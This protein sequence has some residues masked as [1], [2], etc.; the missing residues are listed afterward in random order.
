MKRFSRWTL[1]ALVLLALTTSSVFGQETRRALLVGLDL[2]D[3]GYA[4]SL[5]ACVKDA[6]AMRDVVLLGDPS[7]R[8]NAVNISL[9]S[10][11]GAHHNAIRTAMAN[12]ASESQ[13]GDLVLYY[14]SGHGG[15]H[16]GTT[17][18]FLCAYE[19]NYEDHEVA[20]D[21]DAFAEGVRVVVV[22]DTCH[23]GGLLIRGEPTAEDWPFIEGV[24]KNYNSIRAARQPD[25]ARTF[26]N[27]NV[28][29]M[30][31]CAYDEYSYEIPDRHGVY[32]RYLL[33]GAS[34][35]ASDTSADGEVQFLEMYNHAKSRA[36][37]YAP[38]TAQSYNEA[39]LGAIAARGHSAPATLA[40]AI[41]TSTNFV[42]QTGGSAPWIA[43]DF[44]AA[45]AG[46]GAAAQSDAIDH[47]QNS[48]IRTSVTGPGIVTFRWK[49]SSEED[50]DF[51][52]FLVSGTVMTSISGEQ[53]WQE[54]VF[55]IPAGANTLTWRYVQDA[56]VKEGY[57]AGWL[58]SVVWEPGKTLPDFIVQSITLNPATVPAGHPITYTV[59]VRN[60]GEEGGDAGSLELYYDRAAVAPVGLDGEF[61]YDVGW[62]DAGETRT[63]TNTFS[64]ATTGNKT[65]R[66]FIDGQNETGESNEDNNQRTQDYSVS[67]AVV[68]LPAFSPDGGSHAGAS[69]DVTVTCAT[70]GAVIHY[71]T[72]G[73][74]PTED[75]PTV[76][77]GGA[78]SVPL[79]G[80]LKA[81]AWKENMAA[82][83][84]K[85]ATY[86]S[87]WTIGDAV[88]APHLLFTT[89]GDA[90]WFIQP[91][92][93]Y[94]G[95]G[96]AQSGAITHNQQS[97]LKT[98]VT[99]PGTISFWWKVA[100]ESGY[101]KLSFHVGGAK[102]AEI[103]GLVDWQ[104][105][106]I[107]VPE[108]SHELKWT[109]AKDGSI[110]HHADA[111]WL[112]A[113]V[114]ADESTEYDLTVQS[115]NPDIGV[116]IGSSTGQAG[117]TAYL[118]TLA[119][120]AEINLEAPLYLGS[121][122]QR[123]SFV[124]WSGAFS[125]PYRSVTFHL[126][127]NTV[128][129]ANYKDDPEPVEYTLT[130]NS[131]NPAS[132]VAV[133]SSSGHGGTTQYAKS[134]AGGT[135]VAL[136]APMYVGSGL[137]RKSFVD[138]SGAL[139]STTR[140]IELT[141][142][143]HATLTASYTDDPEQHA[144]RV[145]SLNPTNGVAIASDTGHDGTT[146]YD[147]T[148]DHS[149]LVRLEAPEYHG[150]GLDRKVFQSWNLNGQS[151]AT[152]LV[153]FEMTKQTVATAIYADD[154]DA[155]MHT[156]TVASVNPATGVEIE[157]D[158][159]HF[160]IT[161]YSMQVAQGWTVRL[162]AP[163]FVGEQPDRKRFDQ[164]T[165]PLTSTQRAIEFVMPTNA[166]TATA[167]YVADDTPMTYML[168][169]QSVNPATGVSI[170]SSTA[171][172]GTTE[173]VATMS[174]G[175]TVNLVAPQYV[176]SGAERKRFN[177][178][179][180]WVTSPSL[181]I[182]NTLNGNSTVVANYVDDPEGVTYT[183]TVQSVNPA[184]GVAIASSTGH[185]GTTEYV[186][187]NIAPQTSINLQAPA[188]LGEG[189]NRKRF[190]G[191]TGAEAT[192]NTSLNF[193]M[194]ADKT[195]AANYEND[196]EEG[197][198]MW[199]DG[200]I[201]VEDRRPVFTWPA[202]P[203]ATWY[204]IYINRNGGKY[205]DQWVNVT[206]WTRTANGMAGGNYEW[207][208]QPW[209]PE[210]GYG[211]WSAKAAFTIAT[212]T[213]AA[214]VLIAPDGAQDGH[215]I[216]Y[217]WQKDINATWYRLWVGRVGGG[218]FHDKWYA[219]TGDDEATVTVTGHTLG[220]Y[221]WHLQPWGP[222]GF[223]PWAGPKGFSAP[224]ADPA[225]AEL[226]AP[227]GTIASTNPTFQ[228]NAAQNADWYRV[229][230]HKG[231]VVVFDN[232]WTQDTSLPAPFTL[233]AGNYGWWVGTWNSVTGKTEWSDG[234][235]FEIAP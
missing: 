63:Y 107:F 94:D 209:G 73:T 159:D 57:S 128:L 118:R 9:L 70:D 202:T 212:Q 80:T 111:G 29:F 225:K 232:Q 206:T 140:A 222:D 231:S 65:F 133:A 27:T 130:V 215:S 66:A 51:L 54:R 223:G 36:S 193:A 146:A 134:V 147:I 174:A 217:K 162:E 56:S 79:P 15:R 132:G 31:A 145:R 127:A 166:L 141:M 4:S 213:P 93:K 98:V 228:W 186:V 207:W 25:G 44:V 18:T 17:D 121:G 190:T 77:D 220:D 221:T 37:L 106:S 210:T 172:D 91:Q 32:T 22:V 88:G 160:G 158:T 67:L 39:L 76:V 154:P 97:W 113:V 8:W 230:L 16:P 108:G 200:G 55:E 123:K 137:N 2:Y 201:T 234:M 199:P 184:T 58:D 198:V 109:Y 40:D 68:A 102:A 104:Q 135:L 21:L 62:L 71:T 165:G 187:T 78:V 90:E 226:I 47:S 204:R 211:A 12:L 155:P 143:G 96:A 167:H 38:Q 6:Q 227:V 136:E 59:T 216:D 72:D 218:T 157:S 87:D 214:I 99:G 1:K 117:T 179:T 153:E 33:D 203:G 119:K 138:W 168:T 89:G 233:S 53:D 175:T 122:S 161:E 181:S 23:S 14:H 13:P 191:W 182:D 19:Q 126:S 82:S 197:T 125:S 85:T 163:E 151:S 46:H 208:I 50:Y 170:G 176:G 183:L 26:G 81:K 171:H 114:W 229:V 115:A 45:A 192:T 149:T 52:Q 75:S 110:T 49:V 148:L 42:W 188:T 144:L 24:M 64:P 189:A 124:S 112:D 129:T 95:E 177:G 173:Y 169:V 103:S 74:T 60:Q 11:S 84:V 92:V 150:S 116:A 235:I 86:E 164:W 178:W 61:Y 139:A 7:N 28:A 105:Q 195:V 35:R 10:N 30:V 224:S 180:G 20:A 219:L 196:P 69:L 142:T 48:W 152:R 3:P 185:A 194:D 101:D 205:V 34:S 83:S 5:S 156:L 43:Q 100:S 41:V 120:G 131:V